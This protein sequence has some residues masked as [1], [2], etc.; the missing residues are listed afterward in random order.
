MEAREDGSVDQHG[1][2]SGHLVVLVPS[3]QCEVLDGV[4]ASGGGNGE[5][6]WHKCLALHGHAVD[7]ELSYNIEVLLPRGD[8]LEEVWS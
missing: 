6:Y 1:F 3:R 4:L 8:V 7:E 5:L 2:R